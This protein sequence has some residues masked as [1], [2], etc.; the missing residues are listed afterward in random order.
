M[1][2]ERLCSRK[3]GSWKKKT[4][5]T[6]RAA[7]CLRGIRG[8]PKIVVSQTCHPFSGLNGREIGRF[9]SGIWVV[10]G[11]DHRFGMFLDDRQRSVLTRLNPTWP[12]GLSLGLGC[13]S[14]V[15]GL[16]N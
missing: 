9:A 14:S 13:L 15:A 16:V 4:Y 8:P 5:L 6:V 2:L 11:G 3:T 7:V 1:R 10:I 12:G